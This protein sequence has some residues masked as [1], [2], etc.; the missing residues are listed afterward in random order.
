MRIEPGTRLYG[1]A[2]R[3]HC[4]FINSLSYLSASTVCLTQADYLQSFRVYSKQ[5]D[6]GENEY[7]HF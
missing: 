5:R 1:H 3:C 7:L 4:L 2:S 6:T